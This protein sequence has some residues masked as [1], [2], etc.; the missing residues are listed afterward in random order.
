MKQAS[1]GELDDELHRLGAL[2]VD[3]SPHPA[4]L[5]AAYAHQH[6]RTHVRITRQK[7]PTIEAKGTNAH[8]YAHLHIRQRIK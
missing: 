6:L 2:D 8:T 3:G 4:P 1:S 7:R 5:T